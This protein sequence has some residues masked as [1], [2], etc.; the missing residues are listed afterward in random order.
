MSPGD[1]VLL[2]LTR[3][4]AGTEYR[5]VYGAGVQLIQHGSLSGEASAKYGISGKQYPDIWKSLIDPNLPTSSYPV[6]TV[7]P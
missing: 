3:L 7:S 6:Q 5:A 4:P 2:L 1:E